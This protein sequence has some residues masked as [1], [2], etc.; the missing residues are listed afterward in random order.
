MARFLALLLAFSLLFQVTWAAA[1][2]YCEH[3]TSSVVAEHFG[4]HVH[5]HKSADGKKPFAGKLALDDDC[6]FCHAGQ[7]ALLPV[8]LAA[9]VVGSAAGALPQQPPP[10][11]SAPPGA[12][13]RPQWLRLA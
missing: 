8:A 12:P 7:V 9:A 11:G 4:H 3:E 13:D 10:H 5:V 2:P 1:A 6:G